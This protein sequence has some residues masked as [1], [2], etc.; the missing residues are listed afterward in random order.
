MRPTSPPASRRQPVARKLADHQTVPNM[1]DKTNFGPDLQTFYLDQ[2]IESLADIKHKVETL[3]QNGSKLKHIIEDVKIVVSLMTAL[4][5]LPIKPNK[6][7]KF[8]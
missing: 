7:S 4:L 2:E 5:P 3:W 8:K 6:F 1:P